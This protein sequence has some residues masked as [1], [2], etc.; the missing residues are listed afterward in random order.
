MQRMIGAGIP[1]GAADLV[2]CSEM[3]TILT[4]HPYVHSKYQPNQHLIKYITGKSGRIMKMMREIAQG[5]KIRK[6]TKKIQILGTLE[7]Y[8][9]QVEGGNVAKKPMMTQ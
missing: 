1:G 8:K 3:A 5:K 6:P 2:I 7:L 4:Q 9:K